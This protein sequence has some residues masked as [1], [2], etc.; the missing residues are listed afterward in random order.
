MIRIVF[1]LIVTVAIFAPELALAIPA[2]AKKY[3]APCTLCHSSWPRLNDFG[4]KFKMNGYQPPGQEDGGETGKLSPVKNLFMDIGLANP[5][6]SIMLEG[7]LT[8]MQSGNGPEKDERTDKYFC[9]VNGNSATLDVGGS[10]GPNIAYWISLAWGQEEVEQANLR[11]VNFFGPGTMNVDVGVLKVVDYDVVGAGRE[12]FASPLVAFYGSPYNL[13]AQEI[14]MNSP[15]NDT[16]VRF[17][18]RPGYE[19]LTYELA[20]YTGNRITNE[21]EDDNK[22]AYTMMGRLDLGKFAISARYWSN[23]TGAVNHTARLS[24]GETL[25]FPGDIRN[26]DEQTDEFLISARYS[27][28]RFEVDLTLDNTKYKVNDRTA[29]D[30]AGVSHTLAQEDLQRLGISAS[31]IWF[32][33]SWFETG[34]SY[35]SSS[36]DPYSRTLDGVTTKV[37]SMDV[38]MIQWRLGIQPTMNM[39][40]GLEIQY[41]MSGSASRTQ[42]DGDKFG[43]Q[44][45]VMFH[46]DLAI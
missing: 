17:Y 21:G 4:M 6:I 45:K 27:H 16:G 11:F 15:H 39:K 34:I 5:P 23:E 29:L 3:E 10:A 37:D 26:V 14:G 22:F 7:G 36:T 41:D 20:V 25:V 19:K 9:C 12:W 30:S 33:N 8:A 40:L 18:G 44:H 1:S 13:N 24:S 35:G 32:I 43:E 31:V 46:W 42:A 28:P 2:F 38:G